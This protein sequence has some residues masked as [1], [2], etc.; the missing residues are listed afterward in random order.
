M[1]EYVAVNQPA[2]KE[3]GEEGTVSSGV[4]AYQDDC[5]VDTIEDVVPDF[6]E[7]KQLAQMLNRFEVSLLHFHDVVEDYIAQR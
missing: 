7:A 6:A 5:L 2:T 1:L 3:E 4:A